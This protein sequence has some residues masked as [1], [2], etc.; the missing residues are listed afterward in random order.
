MSEI[1]E[2]YLGTLT[3]QSQNQ[4]KYLQTWF[5]ERLYPKN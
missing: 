4:G 3:L 2:K 5:Q 1:D